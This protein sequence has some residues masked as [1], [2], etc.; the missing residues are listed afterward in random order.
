MPSTR[1]PGAEAADKLK[2]G[3]DKLLDYL[4][5][6]D[7]PN[8]LQAAAFLDREI[9][10]YFDFAYMSQWVAGPAWASMSEQNRNA[11]TAEIESSFLTT[12]VRSRFRWPLCVRVAIRPG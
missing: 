6:K 3:M 9:A 5:K 7:S 2:S 4:G 12:L 10:P 8:K 1:R 11:M